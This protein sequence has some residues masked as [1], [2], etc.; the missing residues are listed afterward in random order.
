MPAR[1]GAG[2]VDALGWL[3]VL[4]SLIGVIVHGLGRI[5]T[6]GRKEG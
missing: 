4:G 3:V 5:F 6:N 2:M 1:D